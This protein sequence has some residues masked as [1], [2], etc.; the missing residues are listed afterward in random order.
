M[1][2]A[3]APIASAP[4]PSVQMVTISSVSTPATAA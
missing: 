4:G 2:T 3:A 1:S